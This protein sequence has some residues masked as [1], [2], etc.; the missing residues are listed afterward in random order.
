[1]T[2]E[3]AAA[4]MHADGNFGRAR[5]NGL[6]DAIDIEIDQSIRIVARPRDLI[7]N[8]RIAQQGHR[9][10]VKLDITAASRGE[11]ADLLPED[12]GEI[13]KERFDV[14]ISRRR[15]K[16]GTTIK[17]HC[18]W[19]RQRN[20]PGHLGNAAQEKIFVECERLVCA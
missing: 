9:D 1:M 5:R 11:F 2:F 4:H 3:V 13:S 15:G 14:C 18:R 17:M 7:A 10:F 19:C 6:V 16:I 12:R 20:F 8:C